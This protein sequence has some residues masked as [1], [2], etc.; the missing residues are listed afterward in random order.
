MANSVA[1]WEISRQWPWIRLRSNLR[2]RTLAMWPNKHRY[3]LKFRHRRTTLRQL[4][5]TALLGVLLTGCWARQAD[6]GPESWADDYMN[7][8]A[9]GLAPRATVCAGPVPE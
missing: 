2:L 8:A 3:R 9:K 6:P 1:S 5:A 7:Q 4:M